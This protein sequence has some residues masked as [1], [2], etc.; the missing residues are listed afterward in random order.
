MATIILKGAKKDIETTI[1]KAKEVNKLKANNTDP[2][3]LLD[4]EGIVVELGDIK[5][6]LLDSEKDRELS[7]INQSKANDINYA[8]LNKAYKDYIMG[9]KKGS[10]EDKINFNMKYVDLICFAET[11]MKYNEYIKLYPNVKEQ[12]ID[13][14]KENIKFDFIVNPTKYRRMFKF[15]DYKHK[16]S[17]NIANELRER[18]LYHTYKLLTEAYSLSHSTLL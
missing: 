13:I 15:T 12:I 6:A 17:Y 14:L 18:S 16:E 1:A 10:L 5:Y 2:K 7:N 4:I 8:E 3:T 11:G 9:I